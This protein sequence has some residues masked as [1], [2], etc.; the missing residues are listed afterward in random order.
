MAEKGV[1][2]EE[3]RLLKVLAGG[4][5]L[6]TMAYVIQLLL[7]R[8]FAQAPTEAPTAP[9]VLFDY[10]VEIYADKVVVTSSDGKAMTLASVAELNSWLKGVR[11]KR[12]AVYSYTRVEDEIDLTRNTYVFAKGW[13][14]YIALAETVE[15][16]FLGDYVEW[17]DNEPVVESNSFKIRRY[18]DISGSRVLIMNAGTVILYGS[19]EV[20][21]L[22][23]MTALCI[24]C[25]FVSMRGFVG[26]VVVLS[27]VVE[28]IVADSVLD[29]LMV[30]SWGFIVYGTTVASVLYIRATYASMDSVTFAGHNVRIDVGMPFVRTLKPSGQAGDT[31][32][33][34]VP[35]M[36]VQS[37][38][39]VAVTME[40]NV[41]VGRSGS[42]AQRVS[43]QYLE[44]AGDRVSYSV[45]P[46]TATITVKNNTD[47]NITAFVWVE[48]KYTGVYLSASENK[49][50]ISALIDYRRRR[51]PNIKSVERRKEESL[52]SV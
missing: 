20:T 9:A 8:L 16:Y 50:D 4:V 52:T 23:N 48:L 7:S 40:V 30:D 31:A 22:K 32:T 26:G 5:A 39:T 34:T 2:R 27:S 49:T 25:E 44:P 10:V 38:Y 19:A 17:L 14:S 51:K 43:L 3:E 18:V 15:L 41:Y 11:D 47:S 36:A 29:V 37:S 6:A 1:A 35:L 21:P 12:I 45:D 24:G 28:G 33:I 46:S 42:P 13:Y